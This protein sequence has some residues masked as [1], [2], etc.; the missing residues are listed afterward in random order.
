MEGTGEN[1]KTK[2]HFAH[3]NAPQIVFL[4]GHRNLQN[5][6]SNLTTGL[7]HKPH[8][9]D[10]EPARLSAAHLGAGETSETN[11]V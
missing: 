3:C 11:K 8:F 2:L 1:Q 7:H 4:P 10:F 6:A 9:F 5:A